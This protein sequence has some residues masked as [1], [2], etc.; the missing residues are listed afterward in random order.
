MLAGT[1]AG[2]ALGRQD[3]RDAGGGA[4][5]AWGFGLIGAGRAA[6]RSRCAGVV[7]FWGV[8]PAYAL[9]RL[10]ALLLILLG[11]ESARARG[12][13]RSCAPGAARP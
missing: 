6:G 12:P 13:G 11:V 7:D 3:P 2:A 5:S 4:A 8:S 9:I 10:G 1:V